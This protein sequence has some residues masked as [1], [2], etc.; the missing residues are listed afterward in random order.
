MCWSVICFPVHRT[1]HLV[2]IASRKAPSVPIRS[3]HT[4]RS[5]FTFLI[6]TKGNSPSDGLHHPRSGCR[7]TEASSCGFFPSHKLRV[8]TFRASQWR[9]PCNKEQSFWP[10]AIEELQPSTDHV[11]ESGGGFSS[12][13]H[14]ATSHL[15]DWVQLQERPRTQKI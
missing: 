4:W 2:V 13:S 10:T 11:A 1:L 12:P 3:I 5:D 15:A 8:S 14:L 6:M 9:S 7:M